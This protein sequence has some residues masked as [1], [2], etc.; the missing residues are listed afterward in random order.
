MF[1]RLQIALALVAF[2]LSARAQNIPAELLSYPQAIF[3]NGNILTVNEKFD[4]AQA[5]AV[6]DGKFLAVGTNE[7][8]LRLKGPETKVY[9]LKGKMVIPGFVATD[10]DND[11][12]AGNLTSVTVRDMRYALGVLASTA[13]L[14]AYHWTVFRHERDVE[15][16]FASRAKTVMLIG[17]DDHAAV[18]AIAQ[19]AKFPPIGNRGISGMGP[20][21]GYK[22][23]GAR[24]ATD[25]N[26]YIH[27][28]VIQ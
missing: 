4:R 1:R 12:I 13:L 28:V 15:V 26:D 7:E 9:D 17:A 10:A 22:S 3:H 8:V 6:R 18:R 27:I 21:T 16:E 24:F 20:H 25:N 19:L 11:I 5:V 23:Y 2:S 14:A